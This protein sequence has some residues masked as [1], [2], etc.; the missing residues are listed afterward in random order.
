MTKA[1]EE[2]IKRSYEEAIRKSTNIFDIFRNLYYIL[3]DETVVDEDLEIFNI[4]VDN[5]KTHYFVTETEDYH[6]IA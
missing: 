2:L 1:T 4:F 3:K 5:L 6:A